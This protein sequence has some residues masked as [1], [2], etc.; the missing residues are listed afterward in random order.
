MQKK[1]V[2]LFDCLR[3]PRDLA[4]MVH[5]GLATDTEI[6]LTGNSIQP[7]HQ[8]VINIIDSWIHNFRDNQTLEHV[9]IHQDF[10]KRIKALK[11]QGYEI[12]GTSPNVGTN[13]FNFDFSNGKQVIVFGTETSGLSKEKMALLDKMI[14]VPMQNG[15]KFYTITAIAPVFAYE[16]LR[17]KKLI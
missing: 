5:L 6:E 8:K 4:Q 10:E 11:K 1:V 7:T 14:K 12:V 2:L 13:L 17:Q 3:D 16:A 9:S 15:T